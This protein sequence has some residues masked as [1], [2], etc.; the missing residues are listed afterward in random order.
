[1]LLKFTTYIKEKRP[2]YRSLSFMVKVSLDSLFPILDS[3]K[4]FLPAVIA[5]VGIHVNA[6]I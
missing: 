4:L 1:M 5:F 3:L 2:G 6:V